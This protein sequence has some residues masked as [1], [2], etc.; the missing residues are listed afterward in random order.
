MVLGWGDRDTIIFLSIIGFFLWVSNEILYLGLNF[1]W[2]EGRERAGK[3]GRGRGWNENKL[4][5]SVH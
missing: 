2:E 5:I 4:N 3:L 1:L